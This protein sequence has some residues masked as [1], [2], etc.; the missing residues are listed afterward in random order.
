MKAET[1]ALVRQWR[2]AP[3]SREL[4]RDATKALLA[5]LAAVA[6][7]RAVELRVPPHG[8][9]QLIAGPVHRRG[10]PKATVETDVQTL[11]ELTLGEVSWAD[12]VHQGR[13]IASGER[14][15]LTALFP[16]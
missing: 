5:D 11:A 6:P 8:A 16:L 7:G 1:A 2:D 13:V 3:G 14:T 10:T 9:V 15:D 12:A 4:A